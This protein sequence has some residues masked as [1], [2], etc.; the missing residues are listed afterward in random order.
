MSEANQLYE[1]T[2]MIDDKDKMQSDFSEILFAL[3]EMLQKKYIH[4][5]HHVV[6]QEQEH[7]KSHPPR[8][9]TL[10]R[11]LREFTPYEQKG[12]MDKMIEMAMMMNTATKM[13]R[14]LT[15]MVNQSKPNYITDSKGQ[16]H[17]MEN[18]PESLEGAA[19]VTNIL[20]TLALM[21]V[22]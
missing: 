21:K 20:L 3:K 17:A 15:A 19:G 18:A 14:D 22:I 1:L 6:G 9:V 13:R 16:V 5:L 12:Q 10:L 2:R 4:K 11:A 7:I 8:E